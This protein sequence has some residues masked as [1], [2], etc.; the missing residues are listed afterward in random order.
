VR[1][2]VISAKENDYVIASRALG[3]SSY[4]ILTRRI[5][6]NAVT[7]LIVQGTLGIGT[8]VLEI[9]ALSFVGAAPIGA[10]EWGSMITDGATRFYEWWVALGP[11]LAI[12][13]VVLGFNFL[14]DGLRDLLDPRSRP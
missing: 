5:M 8:A 3:E 2:S 1:A 4:G 7:P 14:G 10:P 6:P 13:S 11:G 12:L 9:A